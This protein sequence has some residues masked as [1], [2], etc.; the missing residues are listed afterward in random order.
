MCLFRLILLLFCVYEYFCTTCMPDTQGGS[1]LPCG[2][3]ESKLGPLQEWV[4][5]TTGQTLQLICFAFKSWSVTVLPRFGGSNLPGSWDHRPVPPCSA[6]GPDLYQGHRVSM[7][8]G[9]Y[10]SDATMP[11][12][13]SLPWWHYQW[14]PLP[15]WHGNL[16]WLKMLAF[17]ITVFCVPV[18]Y[19]PPFG[20]AC[21][22]KKNKK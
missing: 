1:T 16:T 6:Q 14:R 21:L 20:I 7:C 9:S 19:L 2:S 10:F 13:S 3:W 12:S 11:L 17:F 4:L 22:F 15:W 5:L 18:W 8:Q